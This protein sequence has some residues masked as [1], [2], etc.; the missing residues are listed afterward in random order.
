MFGD[1]LS[2]AGRK[3]CQKSSQTALK[4]AFTGVLAVA[5]VAAGAWYGVEDPML[6][7]DHLGPEGLCSKRT[8][9]LEIRRSTNTGHTKGRTDE[10]D[11]KKTTQA[12]WKDML[13]MRLPVPL[14]REKDVLPIYTHM[15]V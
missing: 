12:F 2:E 13:C 7:P 9:H 3:T 5:L 8:R 15:H 6:L 11:E 10:G 4:K 1:L 14:C